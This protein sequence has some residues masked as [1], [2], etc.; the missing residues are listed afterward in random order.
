M[1]GAILLAGLAGA[2]VAHAAAAQPAYKAPRTGFGAPDLGGAWSNASLTPQVRSPLYGARGAHTSEEVRLLEG[3][4]DAKDAA[5]VAVQA[6]GP[7][8]EPQDPGLVSAI[9]AAL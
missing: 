9:E 7:R 4:Q 1:R 5:G 3:A 6:F 2:L 8:T